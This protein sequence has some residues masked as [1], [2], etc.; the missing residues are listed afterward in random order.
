MKLFAGLLALR[1]CA[2]LGQ[3]LTAPEVRSIVEH[4]AVSA[5]S[6]G[7]TIAVTNRE[8]DILAVFRAPGAPDTSVGNFGAP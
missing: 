5:G 6:R 7:L 2:A 4:A 8:G 3:E 1:A